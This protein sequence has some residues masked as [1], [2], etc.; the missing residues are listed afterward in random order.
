LLLDRRLCFSTAAF[1]SR[2]PPFFL[3]AAFLFD[4][5]LFFLTAA[6]SF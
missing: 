2:P 4:R 5:R 6:C 3:T 1:A